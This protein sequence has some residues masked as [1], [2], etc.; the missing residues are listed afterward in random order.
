MHQQGATL[1]EV[2]IAILVLSFGL[3]G[4]LGLIMNGLKMTTSSHYRTIAAQQIVA[5]ADLVNANPDISSAYSPPGSVSGSAYCITTAC[6]TTQIAPADYDRWQLNVAA[7]LPNGG[8]VLCLDA[9]PADGNL[10]N[11][12][13]SGTGRPTVKV[14]WNENT[15][16]AISSGGASGTDSSTDTCL[17][18]QL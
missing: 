12:A 4:L 18:S 13:C 10:S 15:R 1:L 11:F 2:L 7:S 5:I 6:S 16:V 9:S 8:G 17:T 14:C 3:M